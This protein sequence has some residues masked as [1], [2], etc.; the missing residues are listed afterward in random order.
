MK[1]AEMGLGQRPKGFFRKPGRVFDRAG[2]F[3]Y[4]GNRRHVMMFFA[5]TDMKLL[6]PFLG[7]ALVCGAL[8]FPTPVSAS[9]SSPWRSVVFDGFK[10]AYQDLGKRD[11]RPLVFI[12]GWSCNSSFWKLQVPAFA[13]DFRLILVDLPG[14]GRSDKPRNIAYTLSLFAGAV[15]A[16]IAD[17]GLERPVLIGHSMGY[18]VTRQVLIDYP[19]TARAVVDVD[20]A[21]FRY[22]E[23]PEALSAYMAQAGAMMAGH[24]GPNRME[25]VRQFA[26]STFYGKTPPKLRKE[27]LAAMSTADPYAATSSLREM[28]RPE[29]W[30]ERRFD[31]PCLAIYART[32]FLPP[33]HEAYLRTV[34]PRLTYEEWDDVGHFIMLQEPERFNAALRGFLET[35]PQ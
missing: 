4:S 13:G 26:E 25:A 31:L 2:A 8:G 10:V 9:Q 1:R 19:G 7:L 17:A 23:T 16:V 33:D 6:I 15:R 22:P 14:F 28:M 12:H 21:Y 20:G 29:Q 32:V 3:R 5:G 24:E 27:I 18:A 30:K 11:G 35:L 34:F